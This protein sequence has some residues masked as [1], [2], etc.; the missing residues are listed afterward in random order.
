M[1]KTC[2]GNPDPKNGPIAP[3]SVD[4]Q[5]GKLENS[6]VPVAE[7]AMRLVGVMR[8]FEMLQKAIGISGE[9]NA[10]AIQEVARVG[11]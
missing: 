6:N 9:M 5:Q 10:K 7:A 3:E 4:I 2:F 1:S 11:A 8:Q